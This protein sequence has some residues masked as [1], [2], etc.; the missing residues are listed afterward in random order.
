LKHLPFT[1]PGDVDAVLEAAGAVVER[2]GV[3]LLPTDTYYGLAGVPWR[4]DAVENVMVLKGRPP[5]LPLPI[6]CADWDQVEAIAIVQ[7]THRPRLEGC[8]PGRLTAVMSCRGEVAA[9]PGGSVGVRIPGQP[10]L[11]ALLSHLGPLTGTSA[12]RHGT[13]PCTTVDDALTS[14][15]QAP[16]LVLD[17]GPTPGGPASTVVDLTGAEPTVLRQ[18]PIVWR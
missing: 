12:N 16:D 15:V 5:R 3:L 18:G 7:S 4:T 17:G 13:P 8:W 10:L 1:L 6:L 2:G 14:L 9:A 11:R